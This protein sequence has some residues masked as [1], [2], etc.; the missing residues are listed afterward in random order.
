VKKRRERGEL[1]VGGGEKGG[2]GRGNIKAWKY[3]RVPTVFSSH[4]T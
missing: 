2:V 4:G 3:K 1:G